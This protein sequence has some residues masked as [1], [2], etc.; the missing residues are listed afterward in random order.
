MDMVYDNSCSY[1][2]NKSSSNNIHQF[3]CLKN[4][5]CRIQLN[6]SMYIFSTHSYLSFLNLNS[7]IMIYPAFIRI[8]NIFIQTSV[9]PK[10]EERNIDLTFIHFHI[11]QILYPPNSIGN[12]ERVY[13]CN[14]MTIQFI[15]CQQ[16]LYLINAM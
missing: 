8:W 4:H 5:Y 3:T 1:N 10:M 13:F 15:E 6:I 12:Q 2:R 14:Y 9:Q 7:L 16:F 11:I